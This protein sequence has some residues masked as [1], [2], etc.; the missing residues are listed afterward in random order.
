MKK[1]IIELYHKY[2]DDRVSE[3]AAQLTYYLILSFFPFIIALLQIVSFTPLGNMDVVENL[4]RNFPLQT[5]ELLI[6]IIRDVVSS[7]GA[8]LLSIGILGAVWSASK[9]LK[10]LIKAVN[11]AY[12]LE[13]IRP[14]WKLRI[15]SIV[16]TLGLI[17]VIILTLGASVLEGVIFDSFIASRF[18]NGHF[19]FNLIQTSF[20]LISII[21]ILTL[22]YKFSPSSK[23]GVFITLK[24][25]LP[26]SIFATFT[27]LISSKVFSIYVDNFGNYSKVYGSI[28][29]IIVLLIW[30]YFTSVIII[31]GAELNSI[32]IK[33]VEEI[34]P[35]SMPELNWQVEENSESSQAQDKES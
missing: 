21:F 34:P 19:V 29:G 10:S 7:S 26:G 24:E 16:M 27:I 33:K 31:M 9:G 32:Y 15:L 14:F 13:E 28:G 25:S 11:R 22:L 5:Q 1:T 20:V 8:T 17:L 4:L 30:L 23:D 35:Q 18:P 2:N 6:G 12:D 3:L